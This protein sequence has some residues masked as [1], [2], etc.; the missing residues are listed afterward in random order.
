[1]KLTVSKEVKFGKEYTHYSLFGQVVCTTV[2]YQELFCSV[3]NGVRSRLRDTSKKA[4]ET[5]W[6]WATLRKLFPEISYTSN[7]S[8]FIDSYPDLS[9]GSQGCCLSKKEIIRILNEQ[10]QK[11]AKVSGNFTR[12]KYL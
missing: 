9:W 1:M 8:E 7:K 3:R 12:T 2:K 10:F 5:Q 6:D 4:Y 11:N